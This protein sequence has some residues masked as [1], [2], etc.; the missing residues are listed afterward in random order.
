MQSFSLQNIVNKAHYKDLVRSL[1]Y[2]KLLIA[3]EIRCRLISVDLC[4]D[5]SGI[6][7][8]AKKTDSL[9]LRNPCGTLGCLRDPGGDPS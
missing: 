6:L 8:E 4:V 9:W 5:A 2:D 3:A 7:K 1:G